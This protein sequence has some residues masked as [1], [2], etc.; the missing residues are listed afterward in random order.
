M[1]Y[2]TVFH[3]MLEVAETQQIDPYAALAQ[4]FPA[5]MDPA[6]FVE[7]RRDLDAYLAREASP[8]DVMHT[9]GV[10]MDLQVPL[11]DDEDH[12]QIWYRAILDKAL[13]DPDEPNV[14]HA[15]DFKTRGAPP[16]LA[17]IRGDVQ[18][19]GQA[20]ILRRYWQRA[21]PDAGT[22]VVWTHLDA[23]KWRDVA[24]RYTD[25]E[26]D[27]WHAWA[28]AV[29]RTI[30]RDDE[31][32]PVVNLGCTSCV[33]RDDCPAYTDLPTHG[34]RLAR[35][36]ASGELE[37]RIG[38]RD[39]ANGVRLLLE[40]AVKA[41][42][43]DVRAYV[44]EHG[45]LVLGDQQW[46][47]VEKT[48]DICDLVRLSRLLGPLVWDVVKAVKGR[49]EALTEDWP[50]SDRDEVLSCWEQ[51]VIGREVKRTKHHP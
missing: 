24:V 14:L 8:L 22:P 47:E 27:D 13:V 10:E 25:A 28:V 4:V 2:G 31:A 6:L 51:T 32:L 30:L 20:W 16:S 35:A 18:L 50:A 21:F 44:E 7:A 11:Y 29:T 5:D 12:G 42:D 41:V 23:T 43:A 9:V 49:V 46:T 36:L 33:V 26:L 19:K 3:R 39:Q 48:A 34:A 1:R 40:K 17:D 38:W 15:V 37:D 45:T